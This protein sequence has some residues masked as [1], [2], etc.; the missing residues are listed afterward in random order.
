[1]DV[2]AA[3]RNFSMPSSYQSYIGFRCA[4]DVDES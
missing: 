4:M 3:A 1:M 2:R